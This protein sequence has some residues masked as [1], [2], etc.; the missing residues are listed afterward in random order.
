M[1]ISQEIKN[2]IV[3]DIRNHTEIT[4]I[5]KV[6]L[7][8]ECKRGGVGRAVIKQGKRQDLT[9]PEFLSHVC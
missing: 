2:N 7:K 4:H 6:I 8:K 3:Y 1:E 5:N 9:T